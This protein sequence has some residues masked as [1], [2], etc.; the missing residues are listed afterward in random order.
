MHIAAFWLLAISPC[1]G[2]L[3]VQLSHSATL[4]KAVVAQVENTVDFSQR[5]TF[6]LAQDVAVFCCKQGWIFG[7]EFNVFENGAD[8]QRC[9]AAISKSTAPKK[10]AARYNLKIFLFLFFLWRINLSVRRHWT[11]S[12]CLVA[13]T[14]F[15]FSLFPFFPESSRSAEGVCHVLRS[16]QSDYF[17]HWLA[18]LKTF[19]EF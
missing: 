8:I 5:K 17:F 6:Y 15:P 4:S 12:V 1:A 10:A 14:F 11:F 3:S 13:G 18:G 16:V 7:C 9:C 2:N 19:L